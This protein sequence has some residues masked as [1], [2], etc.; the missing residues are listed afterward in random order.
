MLTRMVLRGVIELHNTGASERA[1][2]YDD[3]QD[4]VALT[5]VSA[6]SCTQSAIQ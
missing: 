6:A 2:P 3:M 5:G 4:R 1:C